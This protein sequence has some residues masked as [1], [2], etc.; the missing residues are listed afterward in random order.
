MLCSRDIATATVKP[1]RFYSCARLACGKI[2][3]AVQGLILWV[4][5]L[6]SCPGLCSIWPPHSGRPVHGWAALRRRPCGRGGKP[7]STSDF[8]PAIVPSGFPRLPE[9]SPRPC[10]GYPHNFPKTLAGSSGIVVEGRLV[11]G[12]ARHGAVRPDSW[13]EE[14]LGGDGVSLDLKGGEVEVFVGHGSPDALQCPECSGAA[15]QEVVQSGEGVN[16]S[17]LLRPQRRGRERFCR[18]TPRGRRARAA[19]RRRETTAPG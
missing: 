5:P 4:E 15:R 7:L 13:C 2:A 19:G 8:A 11:S 10:R 12:D 1:P 6:S 3:G 16:R 18:L 17:K 9:G 14:P